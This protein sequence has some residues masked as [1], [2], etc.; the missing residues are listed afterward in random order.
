MSTP[1]GLP[2][3]R[4]I[5]AAPSL[6]YRGKARGVHAILVGYA[7]VAILP[8]LLIVMNSFKTR[9]AI[10]THPYLT[11]LSGLFSLIGYTTMFARANFARYLANSTIVAGA[12]ITLI[13][14]L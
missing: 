11:Q 1:S 4:V 3:P 13:I 7:L 6:P 14:L 5:S 8:V 9:A 12:A 2:T 10:F